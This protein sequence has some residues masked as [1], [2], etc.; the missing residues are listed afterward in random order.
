MIHNEFL[1]D[2]A[3]FSPD[4]IFYSTLILSILTQKKLFIVLFILH[5]FSEVSNRLFKLLAKKIMKNKTY[6]IIGNGNRPK[7]KYHS[8]GMPSGHSQMIAAFST[9]LILVVYNHKKIR[10]YE[11]LSCYLFLS[12]LT[13]F[14]M[15]ER[16]YD[17]FHTVQHTIVGFIIGALFGR[18]AYYLYSK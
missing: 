6:P 16:I 9:F 1:L 8:Y 14:V 11:K 4:I 10:V 5:N 7:Y 18:C 3:R 12:L 13:I 17:K 15:Y 2:M